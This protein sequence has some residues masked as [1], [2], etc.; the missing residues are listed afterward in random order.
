[1]IIIST[2]F[3]QTND[4]LLSPRNNLTV[5]SFTVKKS[6]RIIIKMACGELACNFFYT[7][8]KNKRNHPE[9]L[10]LRKYCPGCRVH[11][12]FKETKK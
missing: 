4:N 5:R 11:S 10:Q 3:T 6:D 1:M 12:V 7:T 9:R 2:I 8:T